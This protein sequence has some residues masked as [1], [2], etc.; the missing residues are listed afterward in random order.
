VSK[1]S[2]AELA[3]LAQHCSYRLDELA[4]AC[5]L[6]RRQM[7]RAFRAWLACT[8][9]AFLQEE[10]LQAAHGLLGSATSVKEVAYALGF[11]QESQ[12]SRDFKARFG[13]SPSALRARGRRT[14][15]LVHRCQG[16]LGPACRGG[17]FETR[18]AWQCDR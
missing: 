6:S 9:R 8:P 3:K 14:P 16:E 7:Q 13:I 4:A 10:R 15:S 17:A 12:F 11:A 18:D 5:N 2:R 1:P